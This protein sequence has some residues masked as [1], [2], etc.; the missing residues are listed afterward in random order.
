MLNRNKKLAVLLEEVKT[1][2][3]IGA[4]DKPGRPVDGVGRALIE[5]GFNIIPVH[6]KRHNVWGLKTYPSLLEIPVPIDCVDLF[7]AAQWCPGHAMEVLELNPLPKIF[8]MQS[9]ITSPDAQKILKDV[10]IAVYEN[11]CLMVEVSLLGVRKS[12]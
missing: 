1:I 4:S 12:E 2:A 7:R 8:W 3:I 5:R 6:P 10:D 11:R 9:G